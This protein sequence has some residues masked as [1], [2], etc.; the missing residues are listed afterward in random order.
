MTSSNGN[1]VRVTY[2]LCGEFTGWVNN[3]EADDWGAI[4]LIMTSLIWLEY[5]DRNTIGTDGLRQRV[6]S[7]ATVLTMQDENVHVFYGNGFQLHHNI[8]KCWKN[9]KCVFVFPE[10][11]PA[12]YRVTYSGNVKSSR[13]SHSHN[14]HTSVYPSYAPGCTYLINA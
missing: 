6:R 5:L 13:L 2:Q 10:T 3:G 14:T 11:I 4:A 7:V 12:R 9:W 8:E 1:I